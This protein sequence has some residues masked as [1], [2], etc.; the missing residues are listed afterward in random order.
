MSVVHVVGAA[1]VLGQRCLVA[2]RAA[3]MSLPYKWEFPGGK[4][5]PGESP[6][7]ALRREIS[8]ELGLEVTVGRLL[9][10]GSAQVGDKL[11]SLDVFAACVTGGALRL[12][13]H[14]QSVWA[15]ADELA[16]FDWA[17]ADIPSVGAVRSWMLMDGQVSGGGAG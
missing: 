6:Q 9:G 13:E 4:V 1:I 12:R 3:G 16:Q 14:A 15:T 10:R 2:Q 8:E 17:A 5:E 7:Q 11:I